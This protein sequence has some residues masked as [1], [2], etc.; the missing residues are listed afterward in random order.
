MNKKEKY[1]GT[2][3]SVKSFIHDYKVNWW[4]I[5]IFLCAV[6]GIK[7]SHISISHDTEAVISASEAL[8]KSW[9]TMGRFG[10]IFLKK[11]LGTYVFNPYIAC[12]L[13][14]LMM[15]FNSMLWTYL[16][17]WLGNAQRKMISV[18]WIFPAFFFT[19]MIM[20]EQNGFLLQAYE[21]NAAILMVGFALTCLFKSFLETRKLRWCIPAVFCCV[22]AFSVYQTL[23]LLFTAGAALCFIVLYDRMVQEKKHQLSVKFCFVL[24]GKLIAV[25]ILSFLI[26]QIVNKMI[27]SFW[28]METT[29]YI[30]EQIMW[31]KLPAKECIR[32]I[33]GHVYHVGFG[34][35]IFYNGINLVI[36][37]LTAGYII[38]RIRKKEPCYVLYVLAALYCMASPFLMTVLMGNEPTVRTQLLLPFVMGF[39]LQ[40]LTEKIWKSEKKT[41]RYLKGAVLAAIMVATMNQSLLSARLYYTQYVQYEE[42]VQLAEK[43]TDRIEQLG[44]GEIPEEPVV[45]IGSRTPQKNPSCF[46]SD[47]LELIGRSFFEVSYGTNHGTWVMRNF[48]KSLG[49]PYV[50]P[51]LEQEQLAEK[52]AADMPSW[53]DKGSVI[54]KDGVIVVKLK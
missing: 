1:L 30:T 33:L 15:M 4:I 7:I 31:G 43:I 29:S 11:I 10:L 16:F 42:D 12:F 6:Y 39:F 2:M 35:G 48:L 8:Y 28:G 27:L 52:T 5:G 45:F 36:Y 37:I 14:V 34:K 25:F 32:N 9:Y 51:N 41:M 23:V 3:P 19:S 53:P 47:Q 54:E 49:Y 13:T 40:Y 46:Q 21:V 50:L 44:F 20:A 26:Y 24:V 18:S 17:C 22:I 38:S